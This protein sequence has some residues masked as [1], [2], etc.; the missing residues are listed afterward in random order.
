MREVSVT[1]NKIV[2]FV[3]GQG[4]LVFFR[5]I[6]FQLLR[7]VPFSFECMKLHSKEIHGVPYAVKN[8]K[9][10]VH[11]TIIDVENDTKVLS[12]IKEQE[13]KLL[14]KG[15]SKIIGLRDMYSESYIKHSGGVISEDVNNKFIK[16]ANSI[17]QLMSDPEKVSFYFSIMEIGVS[18]S[19]E[20]KY[21]LRN[22]ICV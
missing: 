7:D 2:V 4:E 13:Q 18:Q 12:I 15:Y 20:R 16:N 5:V 8:P 22:F 21:T 3:E 19:L 9:A 14:Q 10:K 17:I 11:F 1:K 6:L